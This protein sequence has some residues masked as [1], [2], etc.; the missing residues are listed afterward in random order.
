[1]LF[2]DPEHPEKTPAKLA[3]GQEPRGQTGL[4]PLADGHHLSHMSMG[5]FLSQPQKT[6]NFQWVAGAGRQAQ[7]LQRSTSKSSSGSQEDTDPRGRA[8]S[9]DQ[10]ESDRAGLRVKALVW[11]WW[12]PLGPHSEEEWA[13]PCGVPDHSTWEATHH[14]I[15]SDQG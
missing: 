9:T 11:H 5:S 8:A 7:T 6:G 14:S 12:S 15:E 4:Q 13:A 2:R 3:R 1:V 10:Q